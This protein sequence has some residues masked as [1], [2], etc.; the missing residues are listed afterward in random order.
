MKNSLETRLGIFVAL[1]VIAAVLIMETVGGVDRFRT[2]YVLYADF[3]NVQEL[4]KGDRV[5]MAGVEVGNIEDIGLDAT[6]NKVRVTMKLRRKVIVRTDSVKFTG[7]LGQNFVAVD[8]GSAG[9]PS[10]KEGAVLT[11]IEQPDL[12]AMMQKL[13]NVASGVENL[14]KS[15]TG[16]KIDN[17]LGPFTDFLKANQAPLT[18][19]ISNVQAIT[20]QISSGKGSVGRLI[21]DESLYQSAYAS[22]TNLQN[23]AA[24]I[25]LTINEARGRTGD[26]TVG[27]LLKDDTLYREATASMTNLREILEKVNRG[28]GSAGK[29]VNDQELY[30]NIKLT[31]QKLDKATEGLEDQGPLSVLGLVVN[32]LF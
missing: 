14:T 16:D 9:A 11:S 27:K 13:D 31:M 22:V 18:S 1:A 6:N 17:L 3:N 5:K 7:L 19:T 4:K 24:D 29:L 23:A 26:G 25:K 12:S 28:Q 15:F 2:G 32:K 10:A 21:Y 8:F 30:D 20:T